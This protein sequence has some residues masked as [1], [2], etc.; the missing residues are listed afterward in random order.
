MTDL[1]GSQ[2]AAGT[3]VHHAA[4]VL[5]ERLATK[6]A[7]VGVI[8]LGYVGLPLAVE[9]ATA[10][11]HVTPVDVDASKVESVRRGE[12]YIPDIASE[13]LAPLV[14][15]GRLEASSSFSVLAD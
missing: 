4:A 2:V 9:F 1:A 13:R 3:D 5:I 15:S 7:R 11:F 10:G 8:G 14:Q 12:S 6:R